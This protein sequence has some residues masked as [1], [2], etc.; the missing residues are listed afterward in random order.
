MCM[1]RKVQSTKPIAKIEDQGSRILFPRVLGQKKSEADLT[2]ALNEAL[3]KAGE[4]RDIV[5]LGTQPSR[6]FSA[7]LTE[8]ANTGLIITR[9]SNVLI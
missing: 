9:L 6:T 1:N 5:E 8:K 3:Q 2:L 4:K 7:L